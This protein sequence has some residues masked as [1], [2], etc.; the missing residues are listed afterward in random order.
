MLKSFFASLV[1]ILFLDFVWLGLIMKKFNLR[2]LG[3]IGRIEDGHFQILIFPSILAYLLLAFAVSQ[4]S[5]PRAM[6]ANTGLGSFVWGAALGL[7]IYGVFD[8]TNLAILRNYPVRFALADMAWGTFLCGATT[9]TVGWLL[10]T[11][12]EGG[13]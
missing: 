11:W 8:M 13:V 2:Q 7:I 9:W 1:V 5:I 4:F 3:A 12:M 10:K 6:V